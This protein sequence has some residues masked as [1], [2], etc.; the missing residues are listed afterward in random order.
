MF[1]LLY[2]GKLIT[3]SH[4][5]S[6]HHRTLGHYCNWGIRM[7][8]LNVWLL[9]ARLS[10]SMA[11]FLEWLLISE[12]GCKLMCSSPTWRPE[13]A[14][15]LKAQNNGVTHNHD[16]KSLRCFSLQQKHLQFE[17]CNLKVIF[18]IAIS[19][20]AKFSWQL[21]CQK[22]RPFQCI[23]LTSLRKQV[24]TVNTSTEKQVQT[25]LEV[26]VGCC[27]WAG[28]L[29]GASAAHQCAWQLSQLSQSMVTCSSM[30]SAENLANYTPSVLQ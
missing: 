12:V 14:A 30:T 7:M 1:I 21:T 24:A 15:I 23:F 11:K 4:S 28:A 13:S 26:Y 22:H 3:R 16:Q 19:R 10:I 29:V 27:G 25:F 9:W 6:N 2:L 20:D 17:L 18:A 5:E 8:L